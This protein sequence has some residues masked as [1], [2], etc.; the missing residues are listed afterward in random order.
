MEETY[1]KFLRD[2]DAAVRTAYAK[3]LLASLAESAR[4]ENLFA[5]AATLIRTAFA[6]LL[7]VPDFAG[8]ALLVCL[9]AL[10]LKWL[11]STLGREKI[12]R[13]TDVL[14][15]LL[16]AAVTVGA[17]LETLE[18]CALYMRDITLFFGALAPVMGIL[19]AAG[20][21]L[22]AAGASN[23]ALAVF[24]G[25]A[26]WVVTQVSPLAV[27][28]FLGLAPV[29]AADGSGSM[30]SLAKGV[31]NALFGLFSFGTS[32]FF[33]L[34]GCQNVAAAQA[35][36]VGAKTLRLLVSNAVPIVG[37]S[38]GDALKLV[39]GSL[40]AVKSAK[41]ILSV[42]F[43]LAMFCPVLIR[44]WFWSMLLSLFGFFSEC[45]ALDTAK[46]LFLQVKCAFD[47]A[48][49]ANASVVVMALLNIG[50]FMGGLPA[51]A[52]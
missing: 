25:I 21:N 38:I 13:A 27:T 12:S 46:N 16:L 42:L 41:G 5:R 18:G 24:L 44:I 51:V 6:D 19:T 45:A 8:S 31:R 15:G 39:G 1:S 11:G 49:A 34:V 4:E 26:Q 30:L 14:C 33:I 40:V 48:L 28:G 35:D 22:T 52:A 29:G 50:I 2:A 23:A 9:F 20:G 10:L 37:G 36:T 7:T 32:V 43:L 3:K 47:F 17:A